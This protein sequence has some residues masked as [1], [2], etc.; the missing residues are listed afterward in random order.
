M[1]KGIE[2]DHS[3]EAAFGQNTEIWTVFHLNRFL[4]AHMQASYSEVMQWLTEQLP[5]F[6][7]HAFVTP[8][9]EQYVI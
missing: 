1:V 5:F 9:V 7:V 2:Q 3:A 8:A 4:E 6:Y